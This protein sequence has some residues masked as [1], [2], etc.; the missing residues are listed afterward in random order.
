[1]SSSS[2]IMGDTRCK[3]STMIALVSTMNIYKDPPY[4]NRLLKL[5]SFSISHKSTCFKN[6][7]TLLLFYRICRVFIIIIIFAV[8]HPPS[9][10]RGV[11]NKAH[12]TKGG[13]GY[14]KYRHRMYAG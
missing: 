8:T 1:M 14:R 6:R 2:T 12:Q 7:P 5:L 9:R 10:A 3:C 4:D 11:V 13:G